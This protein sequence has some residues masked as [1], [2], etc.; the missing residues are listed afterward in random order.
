[1][2]YK[3]EDKNKNTVKVWKKSKLMGWLEKR[4][5]GRTERR[6]RKEEGDIRKYRKE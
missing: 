6:E 1:M 3:N 5:K 2:K 4:V